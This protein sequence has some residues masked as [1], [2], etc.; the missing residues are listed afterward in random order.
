MCLT[1]DVQ[2]C[3]G[4]QEATAEVWIS[5][6]HNITILLSMNGEIVSICL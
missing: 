6:E 1:D 3:S 2:E 5:L 4:I